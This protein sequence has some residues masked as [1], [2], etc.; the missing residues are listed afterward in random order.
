MRRAK[1]NMLRLRL[2]VLRLLGLADRRL[3]L[4]LA[5]AALAGGGLP[6]A[7]TGSVAALVRDILAMVSVGFD[8]PAGSKLG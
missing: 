1:R 7:F 4:L 5:V 8:S 3:V 2:E 6:L